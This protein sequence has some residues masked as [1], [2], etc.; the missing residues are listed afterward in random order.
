MPQS[1]PTRAQSNLTD[2]RHPTIRE[3]CSTVDEVSRRV[4]SSRATAEGALSDQDAVAAMG[5]LRLSLASLADAVT[6][7]HWLSL[8]LASAPPQLA[9]PTLDLGMLV[10][11]CL[12]NTRP[13]LPPSCTCKTKVQAG[14]LVHVE[15]TLLIEAFS[16][17]LTAA[18]LRLHGTTDSQ[19]C[20]R[21]S[22]SLKARKGLTVLGLAYNASRRASKGAYEQEERAL[23]LLKSVGGAASIRNTKR[24]SIL[25]IK[26]PSTD[27]GAAH[28]TFSRRGDEL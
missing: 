20:P 16:L 15:Q 13:A 27:A 1:P 26:L 17:L 14:L 9:D 21:L 10:R 23:E 2:A 8:A 7:L 28:E 3:L 6:R 22:L 19:T 4:A 18:S 24:W 12:A 5:K 25:Q 11:E